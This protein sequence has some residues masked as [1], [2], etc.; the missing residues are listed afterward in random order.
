MTTKQ[1]EFN[2]TEQKNSKVFI[3]VVDQS[4]STADY[5]NRWAA[6]GDSYPTNM[7]VVT[8]DPV[9]IDGDFVVCNN[10]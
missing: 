5:I 6:G 9:V 4:Q 1:D 3:G 10:G 7:V 8:G 2:K